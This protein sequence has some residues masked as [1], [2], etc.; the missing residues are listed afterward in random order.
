MSFFVLFLDPWKHP[1]YH[2]HHDWLLRLDMVLLRNRAFQAG[3]ISFEEKE[4]LIATSRSGPQ[5]HNDL[6]L[7]YAQGGGQKSFQRLLNTLKSMGDRYDETR[8]QLSKLLP[9]NT[10]GMFRSSNTNI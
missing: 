4:T 3:L 8:F 2:E 1:E 9:C 10:H 7:S 6:L 5:V